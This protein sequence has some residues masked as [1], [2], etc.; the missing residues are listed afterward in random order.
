M[1][2][3]E[4][5]EPRGPFPD[6]QPVTSRYATASLA[7]AAYTLFITPA[8]EKLHQVVEAEC[9][10]GPFQPPH[11]SIDETVSCI[12]DEVLTLDRIKRQPVMDNARLTHLAGMLIQFSD[13]NPKYRNTIAIS[14][15]DVAALRS[16]IADRANKT[17]PLGY[18]EQ[19]DI[20]LDQTNGDVLESLWRLFVTSRQHARWLDSS[21]IQGM[22]NYTK[23][24]KVKLMLE[25]RGAIA[26]CKN[27]QENFA[28][29]PSGDTYYTWTHALSK[30]AYTL[31]PLKNTYL[32]RGAVRVFEHG[33]SIMHK[34]VH[35]INKQGVQ[36]NH[37]I[38][39]AYGNAIGHSIVNIMR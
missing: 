19:L 35:T 1:V 22:P 3:I 20:A 13:H 12:R 36:S 2:M 18:A 11:P 10:N 38:A 14:Y 5:V 6:I 4:S 15:E 37:E 29:D 30:A 16:G 9:H 8:H 27:P 7:R 28:Q 31:C 39:A 26:A 33:T 32:T 23:E 24:D 17:E 25:W 21:V 34:T